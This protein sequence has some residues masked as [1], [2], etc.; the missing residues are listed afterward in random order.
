MEKGREMS[1]FGLE[2]P[3]KMTQLPYAH[4]K[5]DGDLN[6]TP[7]DGPPVCQFGQLTELNLALPLELLFTT[8]ILK[9]MV[10]IF[11][12]CGEISDVFF[13]ELMINLGFTYRN[14]KMKL[15]LT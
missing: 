2:E 11:D 12:P 7:P 15:D 6:Q 10:K 8:D 3:S 5:Q 1:T 14:V 9:A 13:L 4:V